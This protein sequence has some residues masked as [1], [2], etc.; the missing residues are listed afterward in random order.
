MHRTSALRTK[1]ERRARPPGSYRLLGKVTFRHVTKVI[2]PGEPVYSENDKARPAQIFAH[3]GFCSPPRK[4]SLTLRSEG[5]RL[6][7]L[8]EPF[9]PTKLSVLYLLLYSCVWRW[10]A[11][12]LGNTL[13][14]HSYPA[15]RLVLAVG[16]F[17]VNDSAEAAKRSGRQVSSA[18]LFPMFVKLEGRLC[19][20]VG[21]GRIAE[22]K[23]PGLLDAA[24]TV[25]VVA[26]EAN[27]AV[28]EWARAGK[29]SWDAKTFEPSD[30]D[31]VFLVIAA[32]SSSSL[33][34]TVFTEA[35][36]RSV[37]CNAV[38]D[39]ENCDFYYPAVVRRGA[40]QLAISTGGHS[41]ALAQRLRQELEEQFGPEY[42]GWVDQLGQARE[43]LF[44]REMEPETR[45]Q[46]LHEIASRNAFAAHNPGAKRS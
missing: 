43:E 11:E 17:M 16:F 14:Q 42:A 31:G 3:Y 7:K 20:V 27:A 23:V 12:N 19:L 30:L 21:A 29:V 5:L 36:R 6:V 9:S 10:G 24:A 37:L 44:S 18:N 13:K 4:S 41:P 45:R 34:Q 8:H 46:I 33:N 32:T 35:R 15:A 25:R 38:D 1:L 28:A 26:P 22:S 40:L 39:P 2:Y